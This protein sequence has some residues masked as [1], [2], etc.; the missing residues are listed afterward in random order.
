MLPLF[1]PKPTLARIDFLRQGERLV[2]EKGTYNVKNLAENL[3]KG[4]VDRLVSWGFKRITG[5]SV[6]KLTDLTTQKIQ[7]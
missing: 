7:T 2:D 3:T 6:R 4:G 5:L 1:A